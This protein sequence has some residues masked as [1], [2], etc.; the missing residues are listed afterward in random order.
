M[1]NLKLTRLQKDV[2]ICFTSLAVFYTAIWA[3]V[4]NYIFN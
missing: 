4:L 3:T 1:K 2:L